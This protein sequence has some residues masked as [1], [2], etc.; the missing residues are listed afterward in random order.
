MRTNITK[1]LT[2]CAMCIVSL[3]FVLQPS[4][5]A[6]VVLPN[7]VLVFS[8][9]EP[10]STGGK[11]FIR[12]TY[13]VFNA[14]DYPSEMF[15]PAPDLPPCGANTKSSRSWVDIFDQRGKRLYG[16]CALKGSDG[17]AKIWFALEVDDQQPIWLSLPSWVY[18]EMNDRKTNT[19]Y[20]SI[21]CS[22]KAGIAT[23]PGEHR[24]RRGAG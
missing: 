4:A 17:L 15:A 18:I 11:Q 22:G 12:Y 6:S 19:K 1:M 20:K 7:P 2:V 23:S 9:Q 10:F 8:G 21:S 14:A 13:L 16:F 24:S 5:F 3:L